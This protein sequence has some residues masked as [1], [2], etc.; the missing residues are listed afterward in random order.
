MLF[1]SPGFRP[2]KAR[3]FDCCQSVFFSWDLM[4]LNGHWFILESDIQKPCIVGT[5]NATQAFAD[6]DL[7]EVDADRGIVRKI[8]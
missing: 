3:L 6:G 4:V 8:K 1:T 5:K 7:V 2:I